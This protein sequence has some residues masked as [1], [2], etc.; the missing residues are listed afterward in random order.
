MQPGHISLL[1]FLIYLSLAFGP[2]F[3]YFL[4][5]KLRKIEEARRAARELLNKID[6]GIE[7]IEEDK[8]KSLKFIEDR[9]CFY[10]NLRDNFS[11]DYIKGRKWLANFIAEAEKTLD[12]RESEYLESK[13]NTCS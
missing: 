12:E 13:K 2:L 8:K 10:N 4:K 1:F 5:N 3:I 9:I 11:E 6:K 7:Q